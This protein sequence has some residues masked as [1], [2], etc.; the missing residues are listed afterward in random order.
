MKKIFLDI[1]TLPA[2][3]D[4]YAELR[5]LFAKKLEK[6]NKRKEMSEEV[7]IEEVTSKEEA[8]FEDYV[9]GT[10]FDAAF[11]RVLCI[12]YAINDEPTAVICN[13]QDEK[14]TLENFWNL[15]KDV[16]LFVGHNIFNFDLK[17]LYQR[18]VVLGIK[19]SQQLSFAKF[20]NFPIYDTMHEWSRWTD[21]NVGLEH[22]AL[23]LGIPTPK[24]GIDG[25]QV[26]DF[27]QAGK[28]KEIC[29]YCK[30][31]VETTRAVY[32]RIN[33]EI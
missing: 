26:F 22:I 31:D 21:K 11:G 23:A 14:A 15:V 16:D 20:R 6:K 7:I 13:D 33:F 24:E 5:Y 2:R 10:S 17:F 25:S 12:A 27:Y 32:K 9:K 8:K 28:V 3:S 1:E 18:S 19:P 29:D 4:K 30:R